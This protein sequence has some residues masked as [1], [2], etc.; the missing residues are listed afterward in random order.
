MTYLPDDILVKVDRASMATSLEAREPL[1]DHRLID[2]AWRLPMSMK[3]RDGEGKWILRQVLHRYVPAKLM[4]R[5]KM[6]FGIPIDA[7][8][9]GPLREWGES[10]LD[11]KAIEHAGIFDAAP[12]RAAW[13]EHLCGKRNWQYPLWTVLMFQQWFARTS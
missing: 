3:I 2:F 12:I 4:E 8:L 13:H 11:A 1:L 5:P 9:R 10:L 7:W 6:G